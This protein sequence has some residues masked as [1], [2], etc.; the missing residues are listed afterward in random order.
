MDW[1]ELGRT[2]AKAAPLLGGLVGGPAGSAIGG[3]IAA[4]V[5]ADDESPQAIAAAIERDPEAALKLREL[6]TRHREALEQMALERA[7]AELT[8]ETER[9]G[10]VNRTMRAE[11]A[12]TGFWRT[13]W[14][15]AFGWA[16]ALSF[17][18]TML[19]IGYVIAIE[20]DRAAAAVQAAAGM[21][22][23]WSVG[24]AVLGVTAWRRS[25]DKALAAGHP[26]AT[27]LLGALAERIRGGK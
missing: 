11:L 12:G 25:D 10:E 5:G 9:I 1:G 20:T 15:P 23:V 27:G 26:P 3:L 16:M 13:G 4:A 24:L 6:E 7:R 22:G 2:I 18:W 8:A 17:A 14:R 19:V 21:T